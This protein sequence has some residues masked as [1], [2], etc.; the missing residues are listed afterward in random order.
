MIPNWCHF[1]QQQIINPF[2]HEEN[3]FIFY[4]IIIFFCLINLGLFFF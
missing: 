4:S 3:V 2:I 1:A